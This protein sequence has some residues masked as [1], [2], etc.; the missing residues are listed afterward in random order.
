VEHYAVRVSTDA[1]IY[2]QTYMH[3]PG[4]VFLHTHLRIDCARRLLH[5]EQSWHHSFLQGGIGVY[6]P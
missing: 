4:R 5:H 1:E 2:L 6:I 3:S